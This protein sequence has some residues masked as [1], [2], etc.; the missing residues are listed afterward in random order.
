M[1]SR[2]GEHTYHMDVSAVIKR[3]PCTG[4]S[5]MTSVTTCVAHLSTLSR[6]STAARWIYGS[7]TNRIGP[8]LSGTIVAVSP[9]WRAEIVYWYSQ[10]ATSSERTLFLHELCWRHESLN[11]GVVTMDVTC[12]AGDCLLET[13]ND[14]MTS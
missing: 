8:D 2:G 13:F 4:S 9:A 7:C 10:V 1:T 14:G 11:T 5:T 3:F 6:V 12:V